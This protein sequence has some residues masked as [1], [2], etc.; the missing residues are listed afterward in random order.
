MGWSPQV[1]TKVHVYKDLEKVRHNISLDAT[2]EDL[3]ITS[4]NMLKVMYV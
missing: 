2:L 4:E 3:E 1:V